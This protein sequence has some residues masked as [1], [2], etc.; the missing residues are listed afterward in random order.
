MEKFDKT[1]TNLYFIFRQR[2]WVIEK[3]EQKISSTPPPKRI[4]TKLPK[5]DSHKAT[6]SNATATPLPVNVAQ[7]VTSIPD[8]ILDRKTHTDEFKRGP[9]KVE[10][11]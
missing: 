9:R 4:P 6:T 1:I 10:S 7:I 5:N 3:I 2:D 11:E 8:Q